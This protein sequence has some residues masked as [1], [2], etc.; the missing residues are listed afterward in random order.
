M[1][2][3]VCWQVTA[4]RTWVEFW[5]FMCALSLLAGVSHRNGPQNMR[6]MPKASRVAC[7]VCE[8]PKA[9]F[10][11][12]KERKA[13]C[14]AHRSTIGVER[15]ISTFTTIMR[16]SHEEKKY[17]VRV[18]R[19][20]IAPSVTACHTRIHFLSLSCGSCIFREIFIGWSKSNQ[21]N[22]WCLAD[23]RCCVAS[24]ID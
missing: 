6:H 16:G 20:C 15:K 9:K 3:G 14:R 13:Y 22:T 21:L 10:L 4:L 11:P 24:S 1:T 23:F 7:C 5:I 17:L 18:G 12:L 19:A 8:K 2:F